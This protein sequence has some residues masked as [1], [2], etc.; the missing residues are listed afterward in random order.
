V[1][2]VQDVTCSCV[3]RSPPHSGLNVLNKT[4]SDCESDYAKDYN[5]LAFFINMN[6]TTYSE[7]IT[8]G[9]VGCASRL[10]SAKANDGCYKLEEV[11]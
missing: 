5:L 11:H 7:F 10:A 4:F 2:T 6:Y 3:L 1:S 8:E 9:W